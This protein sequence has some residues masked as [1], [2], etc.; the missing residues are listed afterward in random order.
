MVVVEG[1]RVDEHLA[2][3]RFRGAFFS[4]EVDIGRRVGRHSEA[5]L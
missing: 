4:L 3:G 2:G 1:V 5:V